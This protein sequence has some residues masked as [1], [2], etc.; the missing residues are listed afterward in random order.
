MLH[1]TQALACIHVVIFAYTCYSEICLRLEQRLNMIMFLYLSSS[2]GCHSESA[3]CF[4]EFIYS[5][6]QSI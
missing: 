1:I 5:L 3:N 6:H 4:M 2:E